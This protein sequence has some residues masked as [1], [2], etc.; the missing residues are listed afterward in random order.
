M[1][2][3]MDN[4]LVIPIRIPGS[5]QIAQAQVSL[6]EHAY[7]SQWEWQLHEK[8]Y[9]VRYVH[10]NDGT[11]KG[12]VAP[13]YL[14][15]AILHAPPG[16]VVVDHINRDRLDCRRENLRLVSKAV[17]NLNRGVRAGGKFVGITMDRARSRK[18][19]VAQI[20]K[21]GVGRTIGRYATGEEAAWAYDTVARVV[22]GICHLNF[23]D[24]DPMP[25]VKIPDFTRT[26]GKK[27]S[28]YPGVTFDKSKKLKKPWM[29]YY[30]DP[31]RKRTVFAGMFATQEEAAGAARKAR[32]ALP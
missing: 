7:F 4:T 2:G 12:R 26:K 15:R 24:R 22:H 5:E 28:D 21:R 9:A 17:N 6:Q 20:A 11:A 27:Y 23:P 1:L 32:E 25:G 16:D 14:H 30:W 31:A 29:A 3:V 18:P 13:I 19:W 8:G 10:V